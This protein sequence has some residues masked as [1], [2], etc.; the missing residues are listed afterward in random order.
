MKQ[1]TL[2]LCDYDNDYLEQMSCFLNDY[3]NFPWEV[4]C[5]NNLK[6]CISYI[7]V[8]TIQILMISE[9]IFTI[10]LSQL[11]LEYLIILN[12]SDCRRYNQFIYINKYQAAEDVVKEILTLYL[13]GTNEF[14]PSFFRTTQPNVIGMYSP[15][16]R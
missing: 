9:S 2:I 4:H 7:E 15:I 3:P 10:E 16:R 14:I 1:K 6:D 13:E 12:E 5:F 11:A 8:N